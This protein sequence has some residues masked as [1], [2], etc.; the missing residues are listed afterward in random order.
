MTIKE[1]IERA[2]EA[3]ARSEIEKA[4]AHALIA[5]AKLAAVQTVIEHSAGL[6]HAE[7]DLFGA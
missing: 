1:H 6:V 3:T 4:Q 7:E 5:I 2:E